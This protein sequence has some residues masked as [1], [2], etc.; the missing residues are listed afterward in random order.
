MPSL[1]WRFL[2]T[3]GL[4][5][6]DSV[7]DSHQIKWQLALTKYGELKGYTQTSPCDNVW[8]D[9]KSEQIHQEDSTDIRSQNWTV[10]EGIG[11]LKGESK[12]T[13]RK[14]DWL[15]MSRGFQLESWW[16]CGILAPPEVLNHTL[17]FRKSYR[18][19]VHM[20]EFQTSYDEVQKHYVKTACG[21]YIPLWWLHKAGHTFYSCDGTQSTIGAYTQIVNIHILIPED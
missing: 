17:S 7:Q 8:W 4:A 6:S 13:D 9:G 12:L 14:A 16:V 1:N 10:R 20:W 2:K 5:G 11:L 18:R 3:A 21:F 15:D 19:S